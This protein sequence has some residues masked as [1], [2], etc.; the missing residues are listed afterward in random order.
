MGSAFW[1]DDVLVIGRMS[2]DRAVPK[3]REVGE[4]ETAERLEEMAEETEARRFGLGERK[5][6]WP[7]QDKAWQHTAH[8]FGYLAPLAAMPGSDPLPIRHVETVPADSTLRKARVK[9]TLNR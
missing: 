1:F 6:W 8:T 2:P 4:D 9:L 7:F 5:S 3:L